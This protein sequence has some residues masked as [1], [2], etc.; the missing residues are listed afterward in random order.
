MTDFLRAERVHVRHETADYDSV[1]DVSLRIE[2]GELIALVGPNGSGKSTLLAAMGRE[3]AP[4]KG[5]VTLEGR[6]LARIPRR[7]LAR[8]MARLPQEP[9][10]PEGLT[11]TTLVE[12]GRHPH[13]GMLASLGRDD[14]RAVDEAM[15]AMGLGDLRQRKLETLSGG[16]RR[17]AW[18]AMVLSQEPEILLLDEPTAALDLRHQWEVLE[19]LARVNRDRRVTVVVSLHD[20]EHAASLAR[21]VAV[22]HRGRLYDI[23]PPERAVSEETLRDVFGVDSLITKD[24]GRVRIRVDGPAD[25]IRSL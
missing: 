1:R 14:R 4:R 8:R 20:L 17:R 18:I 3:L 2:P 6:N 10:A 16:E 13:M 25:P 24:A 22:L 5:R 15:L 19:L 9:I 7:V 23:A 21:R 12:N 11:V